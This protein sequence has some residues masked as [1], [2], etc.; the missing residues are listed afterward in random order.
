MRAPDVLPAVYFCARLTAVK[1]SFYDVLFHHVAGYAEPRRDLAIGQALDAAE[2]E[3]LLAPFWKRAD[4]TRHHG[5]MLA[6]RHDLLLI[7]PVTGNAETVFQRYQQRAFA[8]LSDN[9]QPR[10]RFRDLEEI[11][12]RI[13][14]RCCLSN[15]QNAQRRFL[16]R[17]CCIFTISKAVAEEPQKAI[18]L[19]RFQK[20]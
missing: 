8:R 7:R 6:T 14:D 19:F 3:N 16:H 17:V 2:D 4:F 9:R 5:Q 18:A 15:L 10:D 13:F 11:G 12:L 20:M 1:Q